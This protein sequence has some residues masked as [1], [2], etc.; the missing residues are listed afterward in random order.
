M[1]AAGG[2]GSRNGPQ[3]G[4]GSR[5]TLKIHPTFADRAGRTMCHSYGFKGSEMGNDALKR[6][7]LQ[8]IL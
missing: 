5:E 2:G 3:G 8:E 7:S 6:L 4:P 1:R